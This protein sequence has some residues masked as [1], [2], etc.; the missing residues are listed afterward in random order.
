M[1][2]AT[3]RRR[4][5]NGTLEVEHLLG[6]ASSRPEGL[7]GELEKLIVEC[8]WDDGRQLTPHSR[9]PPWRRWARTAIAYARDG[10]DGLAALVAAD[11]AFHSFALALLD[12]IRTAESLAAA[13]RINAAALADPATHLERATLLACTINSHLSFPPP[14]EIPP[15]TAARIRDFLHCL[16]PACKTDADRANALCALR[17]V[18]DETSL[19][20]IATLPPLADPWDGIGKK[21]RRDL[22]KR[23]A[24]PAAARRPAPGAFALAAPPPAPAARPPRAAPPAETI[25][26]DK[27]KWH[28]DADDFPRDLP[29]EAGATH[30]AHYLRWCLENGH[31]SEEFLETHPARIASLHKGALDMRDFLLREFDGVFLS[32][33][34]NPAG[35]AFALA[36]YHTGGTASAQKHG[37]YLGDCE[38]LARELALA[39]SCRL[40]NDAATYARVKTLVTRRHRQFQDDATGAKT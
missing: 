38:T 13:L 1:N 8:E 12:E 14:V 32:D 36:C 19:A 24:G 3:L 16:L 37:D 30:I 9:T 10:H 39:H 21:I 31:F 27:A 4:A 26:H 35:R 22:R 33:I 40:P 5:R 20:L 7:I 6:L 28:S 15:E 25:T 34:L 11:A 17:G 18:G 29:P 23:L 2:L